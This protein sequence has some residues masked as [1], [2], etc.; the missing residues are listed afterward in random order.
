[1]ATSEMD[2]KRLWGLAAGICSHPGCGTACIPLLSGDPTIIG[3]M[4]HVIA[5]KPS[6]PRGQAGGGQDNY[7]NLIL[8]CPT[9]HS[10]VDKAPKG[11][12]S[13]E[14]LHGWKRN[15]EETIKARLAAPVLRTRR[16]LAQ[17]ILRLLIENHA[18][19]KDFGPDSVEAKSNPVS[20]LAD[21]WAIRKVAQVIPKNT[22]IVQL[23]EQNAELLTP[24]EYEI[25]RRF[26]EHAA[27]FEASTYNRLENVP[28][29]PANFEEM[30][31]HVAAE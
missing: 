24:A 5:R 19:W 3:Q 27:G 21:L 6:G 15:H 29:F 9:C 8:L 4:A 17:R 2:I 30:I 20:S 1:M 31:R 28:R 22:Q 18:T 13:E 26:V 7:D 25:S 10:M 11:T 23:L 16:E 14:T 12:F